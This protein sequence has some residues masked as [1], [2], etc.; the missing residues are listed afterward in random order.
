MAEQAY[1]MGVAP[2]RLAKQL[3]DNGQLGLVA[4]DVMR[5]N[6]L[7]LLAEKAR[8]IDEAGRPV[9]V[10]ADEPELDTE[11]AEGRRTRTRTRPTLRARAED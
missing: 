1:R 2:D 9:Y 8:I 4:G 11:A 6:A 10:K 3:S 7:R 5:S